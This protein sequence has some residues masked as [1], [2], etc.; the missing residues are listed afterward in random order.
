MTKY[1]LNSGGIRN[2][3]KL[4]QKFHQEIVNGLGSNPKFLLCNF[5]QG[6]EYWEMKF[7]GYADSIKRD[8]P[9]GIKPTF[10]LAMPESFQ[11]QCLASDIIYFHGG[12]DHLLQYW[13]NQFD[14]K[15]IFKN[16]VIATNSA[17]SDMLSA[18]FW[19]GDWRQCY[20]GF[21][22]LPIKIIAHYK[23]NYGDDDTRGSID[24]QKAYDELAGYGDKDLPIYALKEGEFVIFEQ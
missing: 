7:P 13:M 21:G 22:I 17:S 8:M 9:N 19:T 12:D 11:K 1:I 10:T 23:S 24:W 5:A 20:D 14:T 18:S 16:K 4:K 2:Q 6:R 15:K 3:P